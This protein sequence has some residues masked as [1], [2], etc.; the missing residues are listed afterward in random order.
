VGAFAS[1]RGPACSGRPE[2][3]LGELGHDLEEAPL[4]RIQWTVQPSSRP[5]VQPVQRMKVNIQ[6]QP[7][8]AGFGRHKLDFEARL[9]WDL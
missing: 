9:S 7:E 3:L 6:L 8:Y 1:H 5:A 2:H 4:Q